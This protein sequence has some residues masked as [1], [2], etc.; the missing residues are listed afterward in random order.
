MRLQKTALVTGEGA[1]TLA[2]DMN[3]EVA[4]Q[5]TEREQPG[6]GNQRWEE[7]IEILGVLML[8]VPAIATAW[9]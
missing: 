8:E 9:G 5:L 7:G 6:R 3:L 1:R 2:E 4:H